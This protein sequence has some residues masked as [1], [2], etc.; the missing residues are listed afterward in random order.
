MYLQVVSSTSN[1][2]QASKELPL[3]CQLRPLVASATEFTEMSLS[4]LLVKTETSTVES[5]TAPSAP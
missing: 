2:P 5:D 4:L 3:Q 1:E